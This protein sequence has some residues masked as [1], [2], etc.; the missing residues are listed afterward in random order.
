MPHSAAPAET[1]LQA[2]WLTDAVTRVFEALGFTPASA[3]AVA[4]SL[5]EADLRGV[6][7]HGL[8]LLPMYVERIVKGSVSTAEV[9][10]IVHD[11][12]AVATLDAGHALGQLTG[13]QA[14]RIAVDKAG[15]YGLGAVA[16]RHAFHF[17][18]AFRY[19]L[20]A[21]RQGCI[22]IAA[23]NTRALMPAPGGAAPVVGN[24]PLAIAVPVP[25]SDP[26]VLDMALSEAALGKIRLAAQ[27]GRP[28]PETW[29]TDE[30]GRP[31]SDAALA[32]AG[33][34][35][36][37]GGPKGYGLAVM[38]DVLT[39][40]LSGG[41]SG[42]EVNGLYADTSIP[43]DCAHFFLALKV[44]AFDPTGEFGS[45]VT[46]LIETITESPR[47]PGVSRVY[48]PG[49]IESERRARVINQ[50]IRLDPSVLRDLC[51]VAASLGVVLSVPA[52][53]VHA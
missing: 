39:G 42:G 29:A 6:H 3:A 1:A 18:G 32:V 53:A 8:M 2:S 27:E 25:G 11:F 46:K 43:N 19:A 24:N 45:R 34:L 16:V 50:G 12:G 5:V 22:G 33:M 17:G 44:D 47:A 52:S 48:P 23:A 49:G 9:A 7:S 15:T 14:M 51:E 36:P 38:I 40:A 10:E 4:D 20:A 31:T 35:L 26:V 37:S 28:I 41:A 13:D 30:Q 21:A